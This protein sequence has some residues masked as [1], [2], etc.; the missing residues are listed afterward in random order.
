MST[1]NVQTVFQDLGCFP[2]QAEFAAKFLATDS[3]RKHLLA[4]LPGLGKGFAASAIVGYAATHGQA[5]RVLVL[6]PTA[7]AY[8]WADMMR[9][10]RPNT[11]CMIVD[12]RRLRELEA[13]QNS[14][15]S[16]WNYAGIIVMS[17]DFAKRPDVAEILMQ[18]AWDFLVVEEAYKLAPQTQRQQ[19]VTSL[20]DQNPVMR[21][22]YLQ[23]LLPSVADEELYNPLLM[24]VPT[25]V[26]SRE[27]V[28]D[29]EGNPLL[30]EVQIEWIT[31]HRKDD[32]ARLL[33]R[34]QDVL[35]DVLHT[36][37][38]SDSESRFKAK[39]LLQAASSSLFALEQSLSRMRQQRNE[40]AHGLDEVV[41]GIGNDHK[42]RPGDIDFESTSEPQPSAQS[43]LI[44]QLVELFERLEDV[45]TESKFE[46]L[47]S[48][49]DQVGVLSI[50][51]RRVC[52]FTNYVDTATYLESA[53]CEHH[54]HVAVVTGN[55][56]FTERE[57]AV[58]NFSL[59]GGILIATSA[60]SVQIP[61]VAATIFYDLPMDPA[62]LEER[63]G[64]FIR[65]GRSGPVRVYA[66]SDESHTL[67]VERLQR[68]A[69]EVRGAL[70]KSERL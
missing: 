11:P 42:L 66:F 70:Q 9:R 5:R 36:T 18:T 1:D 44:V 24:D 58:A 38:L 64:Q 34:L 60:M 20:V 32:E 2:H 28:R 57:K 46:S 35:Q 56:P 17:I 7:L 15:D 48:L 59:N 69:A 25:T 50:N 45:D 33:A 67:I 13:Q 43:K 39:M 23:Q 14:G 37:V 49:L 3:E 10:A 47:L 53:L 4:S 62:T 40:I 22:L 55:L 51:D 41:D 30:P 26:W 19:F 54:S 6:A 8:H 52:I 21:V 61:E 16:L 12:R 68:K 63:I 29:K 27:T 31:H 65:I